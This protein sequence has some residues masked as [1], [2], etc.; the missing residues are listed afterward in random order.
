[1]LSPRRELQTDGQRTHHVNASRDNYHY[2]GTINELPT[3]NFSLISSFRVGFIVRVSP[4]V[5]TD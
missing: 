4:N 1:M 5:Y 2:I 3:S